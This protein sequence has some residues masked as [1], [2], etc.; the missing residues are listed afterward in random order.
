MRGRSQR[1]RRCELSAGI[2]RSWAEPSPLLTAA[3]AGVEAAAPRGSRDP[4]GSG[5]TGTAGAGL[6]GATA[7][8]HKGK[9]GRNPPGSLRPA[10]LSLPFFL[11]RRRK[12]LGR[13]RTWDSS[14]LSSAGPHP[15]CSHRQPA[16]LECGG[17]GCFL[18][19]PQPGSQPP[20][21][22]ACS[23]PL[24]RVDAAVAPAAAA[25]TSAEAR[26]HGCR[27]VPHCLECL[28]PGLLVGTGC[29]FF[30]LALGVYRKDTDIF[31]SFSTTPCYPP[32]F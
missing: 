14:G 27:G 21:L 25:T 32:W 1:L 16:V 29:S 3:G 22:P 7:G 26:A 19:N 6:A 31:I 30:F 9:G 18:V 12:W 24:R 23:I 8:A 10:F 28:P 13:A 11:S 4:A 2:I 20:A 5:R 17:Q 15:S